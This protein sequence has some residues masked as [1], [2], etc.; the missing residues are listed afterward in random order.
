MYA[1]FV[2]SLLIDDS[3]L[4]WERVTPLLTEA[5]ITCSKTPSD[6][7]AIGSN[8]VA[9]LVLVVLIMIPGHTLEKTVNLE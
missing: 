3:T 6:I 4:S 9:G 8:V 1:P 5:C 7:S 2:L